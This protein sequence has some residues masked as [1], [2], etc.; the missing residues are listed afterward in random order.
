[1]NGA[2]G[3][4]THLSASL[5]RLFSRTRALRN[6]L[7]TNKTPKHK[8][9]KLSVVVIL[10]MRDYCGFVTWTNYFTSRGLI[11]EL[12]VSPK[13]LFKGGFE[14]EHPEI[15]LTTYLGKQVSYRKRTERLFRQW[16]NLL[17]GIF[18]L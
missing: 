6:C 11:S 7:R 3:H 1:M 14:G 5:P 13:V 15:A 9:L 10:L 2:R 18:H 8:I 12:Q 4:E 17:W 16:Y